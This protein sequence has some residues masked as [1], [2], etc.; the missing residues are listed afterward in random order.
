MHSMT[1][2]H[3]QPNSLTSTQ[4]RSMRVLSQVIASLSVRPIVQ[5]APDHPSYS[6]SSTRSPACGPFR[7]TWMWQWRMPQAL[8]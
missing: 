3:T 6:G 1:Q 2:P 4:A 7:I 5:P 8:H